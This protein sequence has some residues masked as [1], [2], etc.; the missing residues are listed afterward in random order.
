MSRIDRLLSRC[1]RANSYLTRVLQSQRMEPNELIDVSLVQENVGTLQESLHRLK[2]KS[3]SKIE[4]VLNI[5]EEGVYATETYVSLLKSSVRDRVS[6]RR[7]V[8]ARSIRRSPSG[9]TRK[10]R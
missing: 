1:A 3:P 8:G 10:V 9:A 2:T 6:T 5:L 7:I 4:P